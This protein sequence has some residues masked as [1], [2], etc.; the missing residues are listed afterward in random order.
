M[1]GTLV[2][3]LAFTSMYPSLSVRTPAAPRFRRSEFGT[4][5]SARSRWLPEIFFD[6]LPVTSTT[7]TP[8]FIFSKSV[9]CDEF[10]DLG[11]H[12]GVFAQSQPGIAVHHRHPRTEPAKHLAELQADVA[13]AE[14][15]QMPGQLGE[16]HDARGIQEGYPV[17]PGDRGHGRPAA[18]VD[19]DAPAFKLP[20]AA[21]S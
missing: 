2:S 3:S 7:R 11:R 9:T 19:D 10:L 20:R 1:P 12:V 8:A 17:Q 6:P 5:P 18:G 4:R 13:A 14:H 15:D 21:I 16:L